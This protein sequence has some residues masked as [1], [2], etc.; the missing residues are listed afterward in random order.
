MWSVAPHCTSRFQGGI[1]LSMGCS[2]IKISIKF[3]FWDP[4]ASP[5]F[6]SKHK[7]TSFASCRIDSSLYISPSSRWTFYDF[8]DF[9]NLE[10]LVHLLDLNNLDDFDDLNELINLEWFEKFDGIDDLMTLSSLRAVT[11]KKLN[12]LRTLRLLGKSRTL[13]KKASFTQLPCLE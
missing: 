9:R 10:H 8:D 13:I 1:L 4:I 7:W 3:W 12:T 11:L 2:H 5:T 6:T